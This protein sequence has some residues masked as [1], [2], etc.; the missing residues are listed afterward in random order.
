M[1]FAALAAGE[2]Q[3]LFSDPQMVNFVKDTPLYA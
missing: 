3:R 2:V 1:S